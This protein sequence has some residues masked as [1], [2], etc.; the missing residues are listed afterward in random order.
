[1]DLRNEVN[2]VSHGQTPVTACDQSLYKIAKDI[3]WTES[4]THGGDSYVVW[5]AAFTLR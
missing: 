5:W 1:M 3:Q 4:E 2:I